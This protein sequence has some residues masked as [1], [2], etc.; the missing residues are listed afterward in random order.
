MKNS[1]KIILILINTI[2]INI[3]LALANHA[4]SQV[5]NIPVEVR[6]YSDINYGGWSE[7]FISDNAD[8][9]KKW[10][11]ND[12]VSSIYVPS[13]C[14]AT[15]YEHIN[16]EGISEVFSSS[17]SDLRNNRIGNDTASSIKVVC[18]KSSVNIFPPSSEFITNQKIDLVIIVK[19]IGNV[20][21][22]KIS[23]ATF[24]GYLVTEALNNCIKQ[25]V[26][27]AN[28]GETFKCS[29]LSLGAGTHFFNVDLEL[30]NGT[31]ISK[32]VQW[33]VLENK[34]ISLSLSKP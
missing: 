27:T 19:L 7:G 14:E 21:V 30:S 4:G 2:F 32:E 10:I 28:K 11:E 18:N 5:L 9:R 1:L 8:L 29:S 17:A 26:L 31:I 22:V 16:F 33:D 20:T 3:D 34:E 6:L 15:L 13:G 24:D 23:K 25:G 12:V